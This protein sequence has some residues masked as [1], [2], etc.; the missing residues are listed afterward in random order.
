MLVRS[1]YVAA[2]RCSA[3]STFEV[4]S[5]EVDDIVPAAARRPELREARTRLCVRGEL[6]RVHRPLGRHFTYQLL[7]RCCKGRKGRAAVPSAPS[8]TVAVR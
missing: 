8:F 7:L 4:D 3:A 2:R 6:G 1:E 5:A